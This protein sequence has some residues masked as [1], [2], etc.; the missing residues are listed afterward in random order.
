MARVEV[1][2]CSRNEQADLTKDV[3]MS[4]AIFSHNFF[5]FDPCLLSGHEE[6]GLRGVIMRV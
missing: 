6:R 3:P 1:L 4:I 2:P 5:G